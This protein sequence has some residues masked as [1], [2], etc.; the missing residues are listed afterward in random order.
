M[1]DREGNLT[2]KVDPAWVDLAREFRN[3]PFGGHMPALQELLA[4][5]RSTPVEGRYFLFL[6]KPHTEWTLAQ[7]SETRPLKPTLIGP[8]FTSLEE[9]ERHVFKLRWETLTG[10]RLDIN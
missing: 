3:K 10:Q 8:T 5:M 1:R 7:M 2:I 9:A 4:V 6:S